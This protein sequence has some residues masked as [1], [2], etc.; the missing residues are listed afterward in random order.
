[1][2]A[3][4]KVY[5]RPMIVRPVSIGM[6]PKYVFKPLPTIGLGVEYAGSRMEMP[7]EHIR[8]EDFREGV[9]MIAALLMEHADGSR[10]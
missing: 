6:S 3:A 5:D 4:S 7:D 10:E 8:I 2:R 9:K 1:M